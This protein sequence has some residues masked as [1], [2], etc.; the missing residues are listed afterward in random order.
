M[1]RIDQLKT[2]IDRQPDKPLLARFLHVPEEEV[3]DFSLIRRSLD[4]R[5]GHEIQY[6]WVVEVQLKREARYVK[7][8]LPAGVSVVQY[9]APFVIPD[10]S[11][12]LQDHPRPVVI[13]FGP[14]GM[15]CALILARAG[16]KPLVLE[17]GDD[18]DTRMQKV[19][20]FWREGL[21]D[22]SSNVQFGEGGAGTF[23][24]GKLNTLIK[25]KDQVGRR[26]LTEM[27]RAGAPEEILYEA[28]PHIGT[29]KLRDLCRNLRE[30]IKSLGG[31]VR[32]GTQLTGI[33]TEQGRISAI[34]TQTG[35]RVEAEAV[36]LCIGHSA[37]DT[38]SML[39]KSGI[40]M[41]PKAFA[42]GVRIEHLQSWVNEVRYHS[43]ADQLGPADYKVTYTASNGRGVYSF[44]MCPGGMVVSSASEEGRLVTNGM[45]NYARDGR[46]ANSALIVTVTPEDYARYQ[47]HDQDV[48]AG[49]RF[50]RD[51]E[52][53]AFVLGGRSW[54]A[55][56]QRVEDYHARRPSSGFGQ[57]EPSFTGGV[58]PEN[59][60]EI[61][62]EY[63]STALDEGLRA[64]DQ[65]MHGF[66]HPD[67]VLTGIESR[68][69][70]PVRILRDPD[71]G[72]SQI[73]GFYP[74]G[75]GAGYAGG[76]MSA[77]ID[78]LR[79]AEKYIKSISMN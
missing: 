18:V 63:I 37:R 33:E 47:I 41:Q 36:F 56:A 24:D 54:K 57:V 22:P 75:E 58:T 39:E 26:I 8:K 62:P 31:E 49:M 48:L 78:G 30:E 46:N 42:M 69:S 68:T 45:S 77:A 9:P 29:D 3:M 50:Q 4:A 52:E 73:A 55:P 43:Y 11:V 10:L 67:A 23:S 5:R 7:K 66:D 70:S 19:S 20:M 27:V 16:L 13:G 72:Q 79:T 76:I 71:S 61:L 6:V 38:F 25:D 64:F 35:E 34:R 21:L 12:R 60:W 28:K 2:P 17:R 51:L 14:A 65:K 15:F 74:V 53:K 40:L 1:I 44:C 59:L 32:F